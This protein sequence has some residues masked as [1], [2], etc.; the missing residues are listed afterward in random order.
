[1]NSSRVCAYCKKAGSLTREHIWPAGIIK[2]AKDINTSYLGKLE[3][4]VDAE[5]TIKDVCSACNNGPLSA[6]DA[7]IC[8][9]FDA[10]FSRPAIRRQPRTFIYDYEVLLRWLLKISYNSARMNESDVEVLSR[11]VEF[12]LNG[13]ELPTGIQV[14]LELI[15]SSPNPN[16][17]PGSETVKE[18]PAISIRCARVD[19]PENPLPGATLRLVAIYGF[20]FWVVIA[21]P[22]VKA[23]LLHEGLP[24]KLLPNNRSKLSLYATRGMLEFHAS[25]ALNPRAS[26]SMRELR[27]R[28]AR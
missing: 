8:D 27:A 9:L 6:L 18:I 17:S 2:R 3:K 28:R 7:Y 20:Y 5:L 25:W 4:F 21:P 26:Q 12:V 24:G 23:S 1:M 10:Q 13:G 15:H 19:M 22:H 14:R 16:W 11:H